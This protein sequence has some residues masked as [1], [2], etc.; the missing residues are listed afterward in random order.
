MLQHPAKIGTIFGLLLVLA[1]G[2]YAGEMPLPLDPN[3]TIPGLV[4]SQS[5]VYSVPTVTKQPYG[6][7]FEDPTFHTRLIRITGDRLTPFS[8]PG[9]NGT[10]GTYS[11][12]HY[13]KD[14]PW[15]ADGSL[16][17]IQNSGGS[18][19]HIYLD[20][21]TYQVKYAAGSGGTCN[22]FSVNEDR[23]H[24]LYPNIRINVNGGQLEWWDVVACQKVRSWTLPWS[25][26]GFTLE[27]NVSADGRYI[28]IIDASTNSKMR[29]V[30][31]DSYPT[32]RITSSDFMIN[33]DCPSTGCGVD[34]ASISPSGKYAVVSYQWDYPRVFNVDPDTLS[35]TVHPM[36]VSSPECPV[37]TGSHTGPKKDPTKGYIYD[38]GHADMAFNPFDANEEVLVGQYRHWCTNVV[39]GAGTVI[40]V[41]LMDNKV[42]TLTMPPNEEDSWHISTR[43][44][45]RPGWVYVSYH[46]YNTSKRFYDEIIAVKMDGS[47]TV[48]RLAH[49]HSNNAAGGD[50]GYR[51]ETHAVPSWDGR[52]VIF[53]SNWSRYCS[54]TC[55]SYTTYDVQDYVIETTPEADLTHGGLV[56]FEDLEWFA[57][58][59]L[60]SGCVA[61]DWC[62]GADLNRLGTVD[63]AD[64]AKFANEWLADSI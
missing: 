20:G 45:K 38:L 40:M 36:P 54:P 59:W 23:W 34:W 8:F 21:Q 44:F 12:H 28:C 26:D 33:T 10:W 3:Y 62:G 55:G 64:F 11:R 31:M 52:R 63:F 16:I 17:A 61:P 42:T 47:Q 15:N 32:L 14:Q 18:P 51:S 30:D 1:C 53:A 5:T 50:I 4:T 19:S 27:G 24:P 57:L 39:P 60:D 49:S 56:D 43:N 35:I 13:Q 37:D 41:R 58:E 22:S 25:A 9:I 29:V 2:L 7:P 46:Y 48:E 6:M